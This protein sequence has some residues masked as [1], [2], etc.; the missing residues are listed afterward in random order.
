MD[1][2]AKRGAYLA[3]KASEMQLLGGPD[4]LAKQVEERV[5]RW[6]AVGGRQYPT[7]KRP[8]RQPAEIDVAVGHAVSE[9]SPVGFS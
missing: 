2:L 9:Q 5:Q 8:G 6:I 7:R 1:S 3:S 4:T